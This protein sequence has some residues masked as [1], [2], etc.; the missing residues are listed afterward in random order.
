ML[1]ARGMGHFHRK[2]D[3]LFRGI[4]VCV[5]A[6]EVMA[7]LGPNARGKTTLLTC[8]AGVQ[9]PK[10]GAVESSGGIGFVP[11]NHD[12]TF[13]F[14][15]FDVVL[16]G[17][18]QRMKAWSTPNASDE[19]AAWSAMELVGIEEL[20]P[21]EFTGLSGGQQQLVLIARALVCEPQTIILDEP[22][23]ALD[24]K[25]Q[26]KTL[27]IISKLAASGMSVIFTTHDPTHALH[28]ADSTMLM[29]EEITV[30]DTAAQLTEDALSSLYGTPIRTPSI[31]FAG[32]SRRVVVPDYAGVAS[33][34]RSG[35]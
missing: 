23:S 20:A 1:N 7:I 4:D 12:S 21:R 19:A 17:R 16:L 8:L 3:W 6:G 31:N 30:G 22:T 34:A 2:G 13:N 18:A 29:G 14:T 27:G 10:E 15:V 5:G 11:Q 24:M 32:G 28:A 35:R 26:T 25:N 9:R 33:G